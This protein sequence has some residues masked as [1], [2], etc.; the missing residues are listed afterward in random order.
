MEFNEKDFKILQCS[1]PNRLGYLND[2]RALELMVLGYLKHNSKKNWSYNGYVS[3]ELGT[4]LYNKW[5]KEIRLNHKHDWET[6]EDY[7][8]KELLH[9]END[10]YTEEEKTAP[11]D[12]AYSSNYHNGYKCKK[13]K[14]T[15]CKHCT[16]EWDIKNCTEK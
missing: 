6:Y 4:K 11:Y 3:S 1:Q 5:L 13:C 2:D 10:T 7:C 16:D 14:F 15:F 8:K 12:F 9:D